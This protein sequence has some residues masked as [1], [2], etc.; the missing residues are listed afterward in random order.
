VNQHRAAYGTLIIMIL[1]FRYVYAPA[2][3]SVE[4]EKNTTHQTAI[5]YKT[6]ITHNEQNISSLYVAANPIMFKFFTDLRIKDNIYYKK[7]FLTEH[8][9]KKLLLLIIPFVLI[10][11]KIFFKVEFLK[12]FYPTLILFLIF[13][14]V[15]GAYTQYFLDNQD[16][17]MHSLKNTETR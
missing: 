13:F 4:K 15:S 6:T 5:E 2:N 7:S 16:Q 8:G 3:D 10:I 14:V 9:K 17:Y 1:V 12:N 11:L